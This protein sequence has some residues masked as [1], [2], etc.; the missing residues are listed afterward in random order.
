MARCHVLAISNCH[1]PRNN[2]LAW[3]VQAP[4]VSEEIQEGLRAPLLRRMASLIAAAVVGFLIVALALWRHPSL[5]FLA[6]AIVD[7]ILVAARFVIVSTLIRTRW[8]PIQKGSILLEVFI[9]SSLC[10]CAQIG[11][12]AFLCM[13]S[14]DYILAIFSSLLSV[15]L[16]GAL[17]ARNPGSPRLTTVQM[18]LIIAPF[19]LG[20]ILSPDRAVRCIAALAPFYL[21]GMISIN[22][23]LHSDYVQMLTAQQDNRRLALHDG[24]TGLPNRSYFDERLGAAIMHA[25]EHP[26]SVLC[27]DLDG[28]KKVNDRHGH[29]AG[30]AVLKQVAVRISSLVPASGMAARLGGDEFT[31]LVYRQTTQE[32]KLLAQ[33]LI[34]DIARPFML[35]EGLMVGVGVSI[36]LSS[37]RE[38]VVSPTELLSQADCALYSAKR[39]GRN[40]C[41]VYGTE[42]VPDRSSAIAG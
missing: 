16:V 35:P 15:G 11:F 20:A 27:L 37:Y 2:L 40:T 13:E 4:S 30:D 14:G 17:S 29:A 36:G 34:L 42:D 26:V 21:W 23:Q 28:F 7:G 9:A 25:D 18:I 31:V 39:S 33:S 24:L 10:W 1:V 19:S 5:P 3:L 6:W 8:R 32:A 22:R 12:G 38:D 41:R